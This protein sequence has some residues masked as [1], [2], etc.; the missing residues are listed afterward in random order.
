MYVCVVL[1]FGIVS[2]CPRLPWELIDF[3]TRGD[4]LSTN[5]DILYAR[6][7]NFL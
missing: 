3:L 6:E 4:R 1:L 7:G 2:D 5:E